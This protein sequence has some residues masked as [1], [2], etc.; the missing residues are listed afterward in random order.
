MSVE[1]TYFD[2]LADI[3]DAIDKVSRFSTYK[4]IAEPGWCPGCGDFGR[5]RALEKE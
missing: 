1:R 2:Y 4:N 5:L 3:L